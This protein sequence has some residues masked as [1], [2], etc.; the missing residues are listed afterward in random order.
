MA[1]GSRRI[2]ETWTR[3]IHRRD[4][5]AGCDHCGMTMYLSNRDIRSTGYEPG[6]FIEPV[7]A[8]EP[9]PSENAPGASDDEEEPGGGSSDGA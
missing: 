3:V 2:P 1:V 5:V 6:E 7:P 8:P 9:R 4:R